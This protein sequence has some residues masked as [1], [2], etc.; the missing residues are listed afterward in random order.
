MMSIRC[1]E[2]RSSHHR[3]RWKDKHKAL[4]A[5]RYTVFPK[6]FRASLEWRHTSRWM[7]KYHDILD[8][9]ESLFEVR[10]LPKIGLAVFARKAIK[11]GTSA[12]MFGQLHRLSHTSAIK[13]DKAGE[14]SLVQLRK[15]LLGKRKKPVIRLESPL[16]GTDHVDN[17][18]DQQKDDPQS[19]CVRRRARHE[20]IEWY[21]LAGPASL[22]NHACES[23]NAEYEFDERG[24]DDEFFVNFTRDVNAGEE[25]LVHYGDEF[26]KGIQL[27][28]LCVECL[29]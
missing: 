15:Q 13:L 19:V 26:W 3:T 1:P 16:F 7:H 5:M 10:N 27:K 9:R 12:G 21:Y 20:R 23:F 17:L 14:T 8:D 28:C 24:V 22:L 6:R 4:T 25:I 18:S 2:Q 11:R 29:M